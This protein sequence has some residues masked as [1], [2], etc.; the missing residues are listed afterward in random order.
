VHT[1]SY[2]AN[3]QKIERAAQRLLKLAGKHI[4]NE[5]FSASLD[6]RIEAIARAERVVAGLEPSLALDILTPIRLRKE[7]NQ[8][9]EEWRATQ[10]PIPSKGEAIRIL[11]REA[12][13]LHKRKAAG[14]KG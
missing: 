9:I 2:P 7:L 3:A 6:E 5:W 12:L 8:E 11:V 13:D 14:K 10:R 4:E 1:A